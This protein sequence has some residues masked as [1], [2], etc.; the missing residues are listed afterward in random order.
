MIIQ[1]AVI[2]RKILPLFYI[3][4]LGLALAAILVGLIFAPWGAVEISSCAGQ[5]PTEGDVTLSQ[6][7]SAGPVFLFVVRAG[8]P[9]RK[10]EDCLSR[11]GLPEAK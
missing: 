9:I 3:L 5:S 4:I 1:A 2:R 6:S 7:G 10:I 11:S 8:T